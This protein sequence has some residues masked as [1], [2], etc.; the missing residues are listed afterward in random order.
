MARE[1]TEREKELLLKY[2]S[3]KKLKRDLD[4]IPMS[5]GK[6]ARSLRTL[7]KFSK[8]GIEKLR[9]EEMNPLER[10][11]FVAGSLSNV[12]YYLTD[13]GDPRS[14]AVNVKVYDAEDLLLY[15]YQN[16]N[17][18]GKYGA[19]ACSKPFGD[20]KWHRTPRFNGVEQLVRG[21]QK[22]LKSRGSKLRSYARIDMESIK[23][24]WRFRNRRILV[25]DKVLGRAN[26]ISL[27]GNGNS[28]GK[29][30][31]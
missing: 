2:K 24:V 15:V 10:W 12:G 23:P 8:E 5:D 6:G 7:L 1:F 30:H 29:G 31:K 4:S 21:Y 14:E 19:I 18:N 26:Y 28:N 13:R 11:I 17:G 27:N 22:P 25:L 3:P 16:I 9:E 20:L